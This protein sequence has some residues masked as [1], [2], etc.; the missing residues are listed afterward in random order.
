MLDRTYEVRV[1]IWLI[2]LLALLFN[3]G[4]VHATDWI[5]G[6]GLSLHSKKGDYNQKNWGMGFE[7]KIDNDW[8]WLGGAYRNS[9][10]RNTLYA[11]V[12]YTPWRFGGVK[13]GGLGVLATGYSERYPVLPYAAFLAKVEDE[14]YGVNV[15]WLPTV[16]VGV[17]F[18]MKF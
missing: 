17:Q 4:S 1:S 2:V 5:T 18:N 15:Y 11:G 10:Y 9:L 7:R 14:K 13:L 3:V 8:S 16:M 6:S 12:S